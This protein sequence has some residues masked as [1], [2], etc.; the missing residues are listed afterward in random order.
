MRYESLDAPQPVIDLGVGERATFLVRTYA[1]LFGAM[2]LFVLIQIG[3]F[4]AGTAGPMASLVAGN[5]PIFFGA[6]VLVGWLASR[7]AARAAS[8][9]VQYLMLTLFVAAEAVIFTPMIYIANQMSIGDGSGT[10][11]L[12]AAAVTTMAGFAAL[13]LIVFITRKDFSFMRGMLMWIGFGALALIIASMIF[14]FHLGT[15]FSV[16]MIVFAGGSILY[17]TSNVLHHYPEDRYVS[18]ALELFASVALLFWYVLR[19]FLQ[20]R[21]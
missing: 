11:I 6:F 3:M 7:F 5:W 14:G 1:H 12:T 17:D 15:W 4:A 21:D 8:L 10:S 18:A 19:L 9:P 2:A 16:G 13:T 20:S